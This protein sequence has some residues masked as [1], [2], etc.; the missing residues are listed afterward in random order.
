M[1]PS[2]TKGQGRSRAEQS[3]L[4]S[5]TR[6]VS[7]QVHS[8]LKSRLYRKI[9]RCTADFRK[10]AKDMIRSPRPLTPNHEFD[11][12]ARG[13]RDTCHNWQFFRKYFELQMK[14][15][16]TKKTELTLSLI[17]QIKLRLGRLLHMEREYI[18]HHISR[19]NSGLSTS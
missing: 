15:W 11:F 9:C 4:H 6:H 7:S 18:A 16:R 5:S 19:K 1:P 13:L 8:T 12:K 17:C 3:R 14:I 10:V 2:D